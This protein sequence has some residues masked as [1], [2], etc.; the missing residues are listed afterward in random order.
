MCTY[1]E[2]DVKTILFYVNCK[3][4]VILL[5]RDLDQWDYKKSKRLNG[6]VCLH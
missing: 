3:L 4:P 5:Y 1:L 6:V 2:E